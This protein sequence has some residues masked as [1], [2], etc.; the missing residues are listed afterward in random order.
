MIRNCSLLVLL[1]LVLMPVILS[2]KKENS[3][4]QGYRFTTAYKNTLPV[5]VEIQFGFVN[6]TEE[7]VGSPVFSSPGI[8]IRAGKTYEV[9]EFICTEN[10]PPV[11]YANMIMVPNTF[12][13]MSMDGK[14]KKDTN[15]AYYFAR[16]Q[17][18]RASCEK[19]QANFF[20]NNQWIITKNKDNN[21]TRR[22]Y[23]IDQEDLAEAK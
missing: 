7:G 6:K 20:D 11:M 4:Q 2:C 21:I 16:E 12:V 10:C 14:E 19:D 23:V 3:R 22:E 17:A 13:K 18:G 1:L 8:V 15:C 9:F 5:A